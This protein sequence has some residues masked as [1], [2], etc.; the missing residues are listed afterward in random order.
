MLN[1][2]FWEGFRKAKVLQTLD[3]AIQ[4][5]IVDDGL[6]LIVVDVGMATQLLQCEFV[7]VQS[8]WGRVADDEIL[9]GRWRETFNLVQLV[10]TDVAANPLAVAYNLF[11]IVAA[12]AWHLHQLCGVSGVQHHVVAILQF[13]GLA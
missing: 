5:A 10:D 8:L 6:R 11:G 3:V 2:I 13:G 1:G 12:Y 4:P 7:D 9:F